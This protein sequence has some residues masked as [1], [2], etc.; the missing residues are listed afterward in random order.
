M[1]LLFHGIEDDASI[2]YE[3]S[4]WILVLKL[5]CATRGFHAPWTF[6]H[7]DDRNPA[8][9]TFPLE[10]KTLSIKENH[11]I[12]RFFMRK[13]VTRRTQQW[14]AQKIETILLSITESLC[15]TN[16]PLP[17]KKKKH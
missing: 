15:R 12:F 6:V 5:V 16:A 3:F 17:K 2:L 8:F 1:S 11:I 4:H 13:F 10:N 7:M 14:N 9:L